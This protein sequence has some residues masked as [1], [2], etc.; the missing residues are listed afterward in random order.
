MAQTLVLPATNAATAGSNSPVTNSPHSS[1][2]PGRGRMRRPGESARSISSIRPA[3]NVLAYS[4][5]TGSLSPAGMAALKWAE[6][7]ASSIPAG[8]ARRSSVTPASAQ[9]RISLVNP[10]R[11]GTG[12]VAISASAP[13]DV[14]TPPHEQR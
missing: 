10:G 5:Q 14:M 13:S 6:Y 1:V 2:R 7:P 3:A 9:D 4:L 11:V 8:T 12:G